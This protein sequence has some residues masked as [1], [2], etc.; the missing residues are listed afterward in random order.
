M[1]RI[2][3]AFL[4]SESA[5]RRVLRHYF[6]R[7]EDVDDMLQETFLK[8]FAAEMKEHIQNPRHFFLRVARNLALSEIRKKSVTDVD[9]LEETG[10]DEVYPDDGAVSAED[11]V[12]SRRKLLTF[13]EAVAN[14]P[15]DYQD[16]LVMR[17]MHRL[18]YKQIAT[19]LNVSV[20]TVEKRVA[21]AL[22][23]CAAHL[24][25]RG[26]DLPEIGASNLAGLKQPCPQPLRAEERHDDG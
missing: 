5:L 26:Y 18:Q 13:V 25:Q 2:F 3:K 1:S 15:T 8:V 22:V 4:E 16:A 19:R 14:L 20:S 12:D 11:T 17:K 9:F 24:Q 21:A 23:M 10:G 6:P 7:P